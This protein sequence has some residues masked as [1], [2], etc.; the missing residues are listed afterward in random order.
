M[1]PLGDTLLGPAC[2]LRSIGRVELVTRGN[3]GAAREPG[4]YSTE[5]SQDRFHA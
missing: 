4:E 5:Q 3:I 1:L 2:K